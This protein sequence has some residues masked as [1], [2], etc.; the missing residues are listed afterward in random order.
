MVRNELLMQ[1]QADQLGVPVIRPTVT[2][3]TALG[4]A[5]AAGLAVGVLVGHGRA[6]RA[7]AR[8]PA[9]DAADRTR[10]A[11]ERLYRGWKKA[12]ERS[13][14]WVDCESPATR[15]RRS[16]I[17]YSRSGG[18]GGQNVNKVETK[19][20]VRLAIDDLDVP[21]PVRERIAARLASRL[22]GGPADH[23]HVVA[24][25]A[26]LAQPARLPR[27]AG[28]AARGGGEA[29]GRA[30]SDEADAELTRA[31]PGFEAAAVAEE[32]RPPQTRRRLCQSGYGNAVVKVTGVPSVAP[33][34]S[35]STSTD[36]PAES[37]FAA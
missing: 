24:A 25:P 27:A 18:P 21:P 4:A 37:P 19:V 33:T 17:R 1:F 2:E 31:E 6:A 14:G 16:K 13:F 9:V 11:R 32:A 23:A 26:A 34:G 15:S 29:A 8:G 5:Y 7:L 20:E 12:V 36:W 35:T 28:R 30:G 10:H 3:T 22:D